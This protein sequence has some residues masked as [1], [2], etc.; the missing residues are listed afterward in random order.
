[1][2]DPES[3]YHNFSQSS[4]S[5]RLPTLNGVEALLDA[6]EK[7]K[8]ISTN[9]LTLDSILC[10]SG[11]SISPDGGVPRGGVTEI[12]GAPGSGKTHFA[13]QLTA[14][15]L[16]E[17]VNAKVVWI[18]TASEFPYS[19]L[20]K[21]LNA[22]KTRIAPDEEASQ[23]ANGVDEDEPL[24]MD[25]RLNHLYTSSLPHL[26]S[27]LMHPTRDFIPEDTSLLVIDDFSG[28]VMDGLPQDERVAA[29]NPTESRPS[30][31]RDDIMSKS[32][33]IRRAAMLSSISAGLARLAASWSLAVIV[34]SKATSGRRLG[35]S[36]AT[37][38]STMNSSQW[39]E[40]VAVRIVL[41]R[42]FWPKIDWRALDR[43]ARRKQRKRERHALRVAQV[44]R[45]G[46]KNVHAEGVRFV[47]L[48]VSEATHF[49][50][51]CTEHNSAEP[52]PSRRSSKAG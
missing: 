36:I 27:I 18:D 20:E 47:I 17:S 5:H 26:L 31:S 50:R 14:N 42:M 41:Y 38:R 13:M 21:F 30:L 1:M 7:H 34:L 2:D 24:P 46:G 45:I 35:S 12:Y 8:P 3:D 44:E 6:V 15:V 25:E 49:S 43:E 10:E 28:I 32:I 33:A 11:T 9:L 51:S 16:R 52:S 29:A 19:R 23:K 4:S 22:P 39:N 40:N 48:N 37:M